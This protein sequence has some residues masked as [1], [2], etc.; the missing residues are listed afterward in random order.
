MVR[1]NRNP[2]FLPNICAEREIMI[3]YI[4]TENSRIYI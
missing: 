4:A 3:I 2:L 1:E